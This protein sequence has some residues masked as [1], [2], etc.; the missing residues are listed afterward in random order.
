MVA[1]ETRRL[2]LRVVG[3]AD[4]ESLHALWTNASVRRFLFDDRSISAEEARSFV[5]R[6]CATFERRGYGLWTVSAHDDDRIVGFA[7]FLA[8]HEDAPNLVYGMHPDV[9]GR[10]YATE[11]AAGV[12]RYVARS[13]GLVEAKADVDE[14]NASSIRVL[15]K[16]DMTRVGRAIVHGR[17]LLYFRR[18]LHA[19]DARLRALTTPS[20]PRS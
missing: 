20:L 18:S 4:V 15:E 14:P 12:L 3:I 13:V 6:S 2:R 9:W 16:L 1:V 10:G 19:D 7:G 8:S 11:A 5:E 17:P